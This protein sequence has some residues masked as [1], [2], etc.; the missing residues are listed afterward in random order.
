MAMFSPNMSPY[1]AEGMNFINCKKDVGGK[2]EF[3]GN[4]HLAKSLSFKAEGFFPSENVEG[5]HI[6]YEL[7]KEFSD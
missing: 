4:Y 3:M 7:M 1:S 2:M 6:S 5:A